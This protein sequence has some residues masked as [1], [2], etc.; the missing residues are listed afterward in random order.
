MNLN[1]KL[2]IKIELA[3]YALFCLDPYLFFL[4]ESQITV[5]GIFEEIILTH[6]Y[7]NENKIEKL[8]F[9]HS[10][11]N[12]LLRKKI[13]QLIAT[14]NS[15]KKNT[16][17][18]ETKKIQSIDIKKNRTELKNFFISFNKYNLYALK[19]KMKYLDFN[20]IKNHKLGIKANLAIQS[21]IFLDDLLNVL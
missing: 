3:I 8:Y 16:I 5:H 18:F 7:N 6:I 1:T 17:Y 11:E 20:Q 2:K 12:K 21:L 9:F 10:H 4:K 19:Y 14:Y 13:S 15:E